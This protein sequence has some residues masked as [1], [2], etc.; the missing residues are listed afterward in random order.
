MDKCMQAGGHSKICR[1]RLSHAEANE[2][3]HSIL[4]NI[5]V[6][7]LRRP[8]RNFLP[9]LAAGNV[10]GLPAAAVF[11]FEP[12]V[13][14]L[15]CWLVHT[16]VRCVTVSQFSPC[17]AQS[18]IILM[19]LF[20]FANG[21]LILVDR[22]FWF[23]KCTSAAAEQS[24]PNSMCHNALNTTAFVHYNV[25]GLASCNNADE[26]DPKKLHRWPVNGTKV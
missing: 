15:Q 9:P 23:G 20:N 17:F 10:F 8:I 26:S 3:H 6:K 5:N 4:L 19:S 16:S 2:H 14:D 24:R 22:G 11:I 21:Q 7:T 25:T 18:F 13:S 1:Q 12:I